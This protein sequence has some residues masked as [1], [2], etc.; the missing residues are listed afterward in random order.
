MVMQALGFQTA[1]ETIFRFHAQRSWEPIPND[2]L[3]REASHTV[4]LP[5]IFTKLPFSYPKVTVKL[6][7]ITSKYR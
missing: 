6:P 5:N 4:K 1:S 7:N 3:F 2:F